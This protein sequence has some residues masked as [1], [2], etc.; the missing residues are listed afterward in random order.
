[1]RKTYTY[2][3]CSDLATHT[4]KW[5]NPCQE[6]GSRPA[7]YVAQGVSAVSIAAS[8][9]EAHASEHRC[10]VSGWRSNQWG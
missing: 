4:I 3:P 9:R 6:N 2:V 10:P 5:I 7:S 8:Y 1:M